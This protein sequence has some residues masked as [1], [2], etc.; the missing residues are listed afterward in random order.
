MISPKCAIVSYSRLRSVSKINGANI[1][2]LFSQST[3]NS[4]E[5]VQRIISIPIDGE[6]GPA[7]TIANEISNHIGKSI[8]PGSAIRADGMALKLYFRN[9]SCN[10]LAVKPLKSNPLLKITRAE[11]EIAKAQI[12]KP[13]PRTKTIET[14]ISAATSTLPKII[15]L[16]DLGLPQGFVQQKPLPKSAIFSALVILGLFCALTVVIRAARST[17]I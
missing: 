8:P 12:G 1:Y 6:S 14:S 15:C 10:E 2:V 11:W 4:P 3:A 17:S 16:D 7:Y 9:A 5:I 13:S